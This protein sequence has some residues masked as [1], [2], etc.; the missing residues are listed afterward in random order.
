MIVYGSGLSEGNR[1]NYDNLPILVAGKGRGELQPG[2]HVRY[3]TST[4]LSNLWVSLLDRMAAGVPNHGDSTG[5]LTG[6]VA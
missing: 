6:L 3:P 4:P 5:R 1:H 2:R